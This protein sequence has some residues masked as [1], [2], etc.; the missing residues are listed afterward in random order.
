MRPSPTVRADELQA[1]GRP[2]HGAWL[3]CQQFAR[4]H[5]GHAKGTITGA[6]CMLSLVKST[7]G[8]MLC[9]TDRQ[10][11]SMVR[12]RRPATPIL[13]IGHKT[14]LLD[15]PPPKAE[16]SAAAAVQ[17]KLHVHGAHEDN[18]RALKKEILG[19]QND[20]NT[21]VKKRRKKKNPNP[22]S[23]KKPKVARNSATTSIVKA[24]SAPASVL[25][26]KG[27]KTKTRRK[28]KGNKTQ[29]Y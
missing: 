12:A 28:K 23:C 10:L 18:L 8:Y 15:T 3:V 5:C 14:V 25:L 20:V 27:T 2:V 24:G 7:A 11:T 22:L 4:E 13:Y 17:E 29:K 19:E 9:T 1:L 26:V 16:L 21:L 6:H